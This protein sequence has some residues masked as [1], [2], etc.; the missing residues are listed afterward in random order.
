MKGEAENVAELGT[1]F[2]Y[3]PQ[4]VFTVGD[5]AAFADKSPRF[6]LMIGFQR[7]LSFP[8]SRPRR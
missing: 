5:G 6:R 1:R 3:D 7:S 2:Q 8:W 4:T